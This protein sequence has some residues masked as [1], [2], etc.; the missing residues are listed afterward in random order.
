[1]TGLSPDKRRNRTSQ[2]PG[3]LKGIEQI[4][5]V[6]NQ[7]VVDR[8]AEMTCCPYTTPKITD[9]GC[10]DE[11]ARSFRAAEYH[12]VRCRTI[13]AGVTASASALPIR[14][15]RALNSRNALARVSCRGLRRFLGKIT[16]QPAASFQWHSA[17]P[18][19]AFRLRRDLSLGQRRCKVPT[20]G[21]MHGP[22][23]L[24]RKQTS[25]KPE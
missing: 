17:Q 11:L 3:D 9:S 20:F 23:I 21:R 7:I 5:K 13:W 10:W 15:W 19:R 24:A 12:L 2:I 4:T 1:V 16:L 14:T 22:S 18:S 25:S 6:W 8:T